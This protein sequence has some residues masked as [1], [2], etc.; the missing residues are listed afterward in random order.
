[1]KLS[2]KHLALG[3]ALCEE[4]LGVVP[5]PEQRK[6]QTITSTWLQESFGVMS[7]D[8]SQQQIECC[9]RASILRLIGCVLMLDMSQNRDN[10]KWLP[11]L[12]N[13]KKPEVIVGAQ[14]AY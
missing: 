9:A 2:D 12:Q 13:F 11:L 5:P 7:Y 8:A 10:L 1:M 3:I 4:L 14:H 6:D